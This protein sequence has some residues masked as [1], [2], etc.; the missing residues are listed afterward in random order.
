MTQ[1][2]IAERLRSGPLGEVYRSG[3]HDE[4]TPAG[5]VI[6]R[7]IDGCISVGAAS[8][9][10]VAIALIKNLRRLSDG[11]FRSALEAAAVEVPIVIR[12]D[13]SMVVGHEVS[14]PSDPLVT[15]THASAKG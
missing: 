11:Q 6:V 1:T 9:I 8:E 14:A 12:S 10:E 15:A 3:W 5:S 2:E 13:G 4:P 7:T